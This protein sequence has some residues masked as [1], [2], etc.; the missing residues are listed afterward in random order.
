MRKN[1]SRELAIRQGDWAYIKSGSGG[2]EEPARFCDVRGY[3]NDEYPGE[4]YGPSED[5]DQ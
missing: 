5:P 4:L 2:T 1:C 3:T